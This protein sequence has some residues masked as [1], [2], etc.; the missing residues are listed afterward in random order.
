MFV[1]SLVFSA[2][3]LFFL[4]FLCGF[5]WAFLSFWLF[6]GFGCL[7]VLVLVFDF[8]VLVGIVGIGVA[9]AIE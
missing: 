7:L 6:G 4:H 2:L 3:S 8:L 9:S 5:F 1:V